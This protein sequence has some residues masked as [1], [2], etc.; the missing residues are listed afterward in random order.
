[1]ESALK[2]AL[3]NLKTFKNYSPKNIAL[4]GRSFVPFLKTLPGAAERSVASGIGK[5]DNRV[6]AKTSG[7]VDDL[8]RR[9]AEAQAAPAPWEKNRATPTPTRMPTPTPTEKPGWKLNLPSIKLPNM[10]SNKSTPTAAPTATPTPWP[11]EPTRDELIRAI[12]EGA[13]DHPV[14]TMAAQMVD[15][16][17]KLPVFQKYPFLPVAVSHLES[18]GFKDFSTPDAKRPGHMRTTLPRQGFGYGVGVEGYNPPIERVLDDMMSA[19]GTDRAGEDE[20]RRRTAGYYQPFRDDPD[21]LDVAFSLKYAGPRTEK[22]PN[23]GE[24]YAR[25]LRGQ[26]NKYAEIL[27]RIMRERGGSYPN[28]Y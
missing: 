21:D 28:R 17:Q 1:M 26:F 3:Q 22:N 25:N 11:K 12:E 7:Y 10:F 2:Q 15:R 14:A 24:V 5:F 9:N 20:D 4:Q 23:A 8:K 6:N 19:I 27:D 18:Q 13:G 16:G